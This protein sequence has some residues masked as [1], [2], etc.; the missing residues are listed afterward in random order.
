MVRREGRRGGGKRVWSHLLTRA[1]P[2]L[3]RGG[4]GG[5]GKGVTRAEQADDEEERDRGGGGDDGGEASSDGGRGEI[6]GKGGMC[7]SVRNQA[8][9]SDSL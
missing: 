5:E 6:R 3:L 9:T 2:Y 7:D 1:R 8:V 4:Q